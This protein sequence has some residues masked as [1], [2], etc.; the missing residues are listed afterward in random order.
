MSTTRDYFDTSVTG[1]DIGCGFRVPSPADDDG[2]AVTCGQPVVAV[3]ITADGRH[4]GIYACYEHAVSA[5]R[6]DGPV[7][8]A[9]GQEPECEGA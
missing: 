6:D 1:M 8:W 5:E 2:G 4:E 7:F 9:R 3:Y